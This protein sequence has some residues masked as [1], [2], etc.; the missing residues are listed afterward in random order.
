[1]DK[2]EKKRLNQAK[3]KIK[4]KENKKHGKEALLRRQQENDGDASLSQSDYQEDIRR[5]ENPDFDPPKLKRRDI[6]NKSN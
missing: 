4:Q 1:M 2:R 5:P 3:R 6:D